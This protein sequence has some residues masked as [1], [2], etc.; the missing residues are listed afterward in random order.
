MIIPSRLSSLSAAFRCGDGFHA[1][2]SA[3]LSALD[4]HGRHDAG[5]SDLDGFSG[6]FEAIIRTSPGPL[7]VERRTISKVASFTSRGL[8]VCFGIRLVCHNRPPVEIQVANYRLT[9]RD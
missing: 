9:A 4:A 1:A 8:L 2:P 3:Y 7:S 5:R 6:S